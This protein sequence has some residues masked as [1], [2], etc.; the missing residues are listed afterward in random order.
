MPLEFDNVRA[1]LLTE[2]QKMV[3]FDITSPR[4]SSQGSW[5]GGAQKNM[6]RIV[7]ALEQG[8]RSKSNI[9][10][11]EMRELIKSPLSSEF[12][13]TNSIV[14]RLLLVQ[15]SCSK[16]LNSWCG[17]SSDLNEFRF[18]TERYAVLNDI[19]NKIE[20]RGLKEIKQA[21]T[22]NEVSDICFQSQ[23]TKFDWHTLHNKDFEDMTKTDYL[24]VK[25]RD[26]Q[27]LTSKNVM[28]AIDRVER[29][30]MKGLRSFYSFCCEFVHPNVGD[31]ISCSFDI[32]FLIPND[33]NKL[34]SRKM[35]ALS[36]PSEL[37]GDAKLVFNSYL[38]ATKILK[39]LNS[40]VPT[41]L[42]IVLR[43]KAF[44]KKHIHGGVKIQ[45]CF[46]PN[47]LCPCG[48]GSSVKNCLKKP[49]RG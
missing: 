33:G 4:L 24:F 25:E 8:T 22:L 35:S 14:N 40:R 5:G 49:L 7:E 34:I 44:T 32:K 17:T 11:F 45:K 27:E 20:E 48:S 43:T 15:V 28:S 2:C 19:L 30:R 21:E 6:V 31:A 16:L 37:P 23:G 1:E 41:M 13:I 47:D 46:E 42:K 36:K 38:F 3:N 9:S 10:A 29:A 26:I 18:I 39:D 12:N